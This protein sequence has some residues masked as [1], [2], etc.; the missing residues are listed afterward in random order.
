MVNDSKSNRVSF[1]MCGRFLSSGSV[2]LSTA[3]VLAWAQGCAK[4]QPKG[5]GA[6]EQS[7]LSAQAP[8]QPEIIPTNRVEGEAFLLEWKA[9]AGAPGS[10][11]TGQLVLTPKAPF[12]CNMEY[13]YKL[14][15]SA[16][17]VELA[18]AEIVK[19]DIAVDT[20]Q[21]TVPVEYK[22]P[23]EP[24]AIDAL[25]AFSVCTDDK[26]LIERTQLKLTAQAR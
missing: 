2:L 12:K 20:K 7:T 11:T 3:I 23:T 5:S 6:S 9:A 26:C 22:M 16:A 25:L 10:A 1:V 15:V 17:S 18:K 4:E 8:S 13:P 24:Q 14:K 19:P 21:V